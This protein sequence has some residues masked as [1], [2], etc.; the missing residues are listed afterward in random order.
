MSLFLRKRDVL[1]TPPPLII[2]D[3]GATS[4]INANLVLIVTLVLVLAVTGVG[5]YL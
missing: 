3:A 4:K 1:N 5:G 2:T